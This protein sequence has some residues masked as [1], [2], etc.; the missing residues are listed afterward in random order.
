[1][2]PHFVPGMRV[3]GGEIRRTRNLP[4]ML[5]DALLHVVGKRLVLIARRRFELAEP[6]D[7][8]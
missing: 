8:R 7:E 5:R 4:I 6:L 3:D 2:N 1:M